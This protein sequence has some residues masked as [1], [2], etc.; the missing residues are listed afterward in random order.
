MS[1]LSAL[2]LGTYDTI[3]NCLTPA[4]KIILPTWPLHPFRS[5]A[6]SSGIAFI[7]VID[8]CSSSTSPSGDSIV[9]QKK[10]S[11]PMSEAPSI[12][13]PFLPPSL[14]TCLTSFSRALA[15][16]LASLAALS[17]ALSAG[18]G[19]GASTFFSL[20]SLGGFS[21][22][23]FFFPSLAGVGGAAGAGAGEGAAGAASK[24]TSVPGNI[25]TLAAERLAIWLYQR[26]AC[27]NSVAGLEMALNT[28][29]SFWLGMNPST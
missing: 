2:S 23:S 29:M 20:G 25:A 5:S 1:T 28:L 4:L 27:V 11:P 16:S 10:S 14:T 19:A 7:A 9:V 13:T 26:R 22:F 24:E 18:A 12:S 15:A 6:P 8:I 17:S 21:F 3:A